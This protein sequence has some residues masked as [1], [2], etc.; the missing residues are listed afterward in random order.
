MIALNCGEIEG[1][2][3]V[4][5]S[6]TDIYRGEFVAQALNEVKRLLKEGYCNRV[7]DSYGVKS[8][9]DTVKRG[10]NAARLEGSLRLLAV[11]V[12]LVAM[13]HV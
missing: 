7:T 6:I 13:N 3:V 8:R 2:G 5:G 10:T 9:E 1:W 4:A 11:D 12:T